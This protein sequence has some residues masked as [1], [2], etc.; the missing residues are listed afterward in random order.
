MPYFVLI[1]SAFFFYWY[2]E[3]YLYLRKLGRI[4]IRIHVNGSRGKTT[5][6]RMIASGL[7][8]GGLKTIAKTTGTIPSLICEDG[9]EFS[10]NRRG[11][12]NIREQCKIISRASKKGVDAVV[13][14]CMAI[15][16]ELQWV[17]EHRLIRSTIGAMTNIRLDH[18]EDLERPGIQDVASSLKM[19]IPL[20]GKLVTSDRNFFPFLSKEAK[21]LGTEVIFADP[22]KVSDESWQTPSYI[23]FRENI[24]IA[25]KVCQLVGV[26][27]KTALQGIREAK[28][29][30]G[31]L[32]VFKTP[33]EKKTVYFINLFAVNDLSSLRIVRNRLKENDLI[34]NLPTVAILN[35]RKDRMLRCA[36]FAN[37]LASEF[38]FCKVILAGTPLGP[39]RRILARKFQETKSIMAIKR[40]EELPKVIA[41]FPFKETAL[42]GLGN[43]QGMGLE[44]IEYFRKKGKE[45]CSPNQ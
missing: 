39:I 14:E 13:L 10:L 21:K 17:S 18:L 4:P 16:P 11:R 41:D 28:L 25:L 3:Y 37:A 15:K 5:V 9:R 1:I 23:N 34:K 35:I 7:R 19:T 45:I 8:K 24:A 26:E 2:L 6:T 33:L 12:A 43:T 27:E 22:S 40:K 38:D 30:P 29:D 44:L 31:A 36:E 20:G 32:K 42:Y